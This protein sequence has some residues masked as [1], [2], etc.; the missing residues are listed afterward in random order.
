MQLRV[1]L[2][3]VCH[4][5]MV[6]FR[7][8]WSKNGLAKNQFYLQLHRASIDIQ[9]QPAGMSGMS[10]MSNLAAARFLLHQ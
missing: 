5:R 9:K 4:T 6:V 2:N 8:W 3:P 1:D 10:G 7:A